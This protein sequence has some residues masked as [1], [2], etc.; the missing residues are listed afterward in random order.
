MDRRQMAHAVPRRTRRVG[1]ASLKGGAIA[2]WLLVMSACRPVPYS[3]NYRSEPD[4]RGSEY[5]IGPLDQ[6]SVVVWKNKELSADVTVRPDGVVTLPL[7]GDVKAGGRTPAAVQSEV[8]KR[9]GD[10]IRDE[11]LVVSVG[12]SAVNSYSFTVSGNVEHTGFYSAKTYVTALEAIAMAGGPN[13]FAGD[14]M[15]I[16]RGSPSRRIPIDLRTAV[17]GEHPEENLVVLRGDVIVV[18]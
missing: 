16:I 7:I 5:Q 17:S 11:E 6:L 10:Y 2:C 3:Y 18:P 12:V 13:R 14:S 8:K 15:F 9:L 4:P 1:E